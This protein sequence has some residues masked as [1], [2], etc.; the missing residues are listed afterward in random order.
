MLQ[1]GDE[2]DGDGQL[3]HP[4]GIAAYKEKVYVADSANSHIAVFYTN[5]NFSATSL[6]GVYMT[7]TI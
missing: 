2:G 1:F 3:N 4:M 7:L 6:V 5:G